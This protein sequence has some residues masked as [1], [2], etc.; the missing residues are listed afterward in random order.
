MM[1]PIVTR[2]RPSL[3]RR[4]VPATALPAAPVIGTM[5]GIMLR[6]VMTF[7]YFSLF[8]YLFLIIGSPVFAYL[9]EKTASIIE[10]KDFPFSFSQ[11][12]KDSVR[13]NQLR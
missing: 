7:F 11:L 10:G 3:R 4:Y 13:G 6:L 9:S 5:I 8:K 2:L 1:L 12:I